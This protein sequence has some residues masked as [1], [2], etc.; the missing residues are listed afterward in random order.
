[1][2]N[3]SK[4]NYVMCFLALFSCGKSE[5]ENVPAPVAGFTFERNEENLLEIHFTNTSQNAVSYSWDFGDNSAYSTEKD[6][7]HT[8][9]Y[10][11]KYQVTLIAKNSE[12]VSDMETQQ[13]E[14]TQPIDPNAAIP[15]TVRMTDHNA[16]QLTIT[17]T[18]DGWE[19]DMN[20]NDPYFWL[21]AAKDIDFSTHFIL[22]FEAK[23]MADNMPGHPSF[24]VFLQEPRYPD[25]CIDWDL[26]Y[27]VPSSDWT[28]IS[29]DLTGARETPDPFNTFRCKFGKT[30]AE[31]IRKIAIRNIAVRVPSEE[32]KAVVTASIRGTGN[33]RCTVAP[34]GSGG[35][36][37]VTAAEVD[38]YFFIDAASPIL[39]GANHLLTFESKNTEEADLCMF[40]GS[41][42]GG[43]YVSEQNAAFRIPASDGWVNNAFDLSSVLFYGPPVP[44]TW[45]RIRIGI[46]AGGLVRTVNIRNIKIQH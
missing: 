38:P 45:M 20:G 2:K 26:G 29:V 31:A 18:G 17:S 36:T 30:E 8:Y 43:F 28:T 46:E 34:D 35:W 1:M 16:E 12:S 19:L 41:Y 33:E 32:E 13:V 10:G 7:V 21:D 24:I 37:I 3:F 25:Y 22:S 11:G 4:L 39:F 6:P 5:K 14:V 42:D 23:V 15:V 44:L 27:T 9:S 40:V